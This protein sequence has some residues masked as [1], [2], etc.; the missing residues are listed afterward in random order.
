M[1]QG[2][3]LSLPAVTPDGELYILGEWL[4]QSQ[5]G[6]Q[7][8]DLQ[9]EAWGEEGHPLITSLGHQDPA[10]LAPLISPATVFPAC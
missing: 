7:A 4:L 10:G 2:L 6:P 5:L 1:A 9:R 8:Q 3:F